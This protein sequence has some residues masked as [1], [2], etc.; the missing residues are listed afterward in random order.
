VASGTQVLSRRS[1]NRALL[2]RQ[3]LLHRVRLSAAAT[4]E[5]LVGM[6]AQVPDLPYVGLWS[7]LEAFDRQELSRLVETRRAVRASMHRCTIHLVTARD[8]LRLRPLFQPVLER[9][10]ERG[11]PFG[12]Q[13]AGVDR[14][15]LLA[16]GRELLGESPLT[17]SELGKLLGQRW[18]GMPPE[19]LAYALRYMEPLVF[20][21]PRG[22]WGGRGQ[23]RTTTVEAWLGRPVG[24]PSSLD[25]LVLRYL[26]AFGPA[27]VADMQAWSGMT[28]TREVFERLRLGLR[29]FRDVRGR[30]LFD[31]PRAP[32]PDPDT[33]ASPRFLPDYDNIL[34]AHADRSRILGPGKHIGMF[35]SNAVIKGSLLLDGFVRAIWMPIKGE[36]SSKVLIT[37]FDEPIQK[38]DRDQ[39]VAEGLRLL[40]FLAPGAKHSIQFGPARS[41]ATRRQEPAVPERRQPRDLSARSPAPPRRPSGSTASRR[42]A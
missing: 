31:L 14:Q 3:L 6:Q 36:R 27:T 28:R 33:P 41:S 32:R 40:A 12:R 2:A 19:P 17:V 34:L 21:P 25:D 22:T 24:P 16:A 39:V 38:K 30:E 8:Y 18:P 10:F 23:V 1:L 29:T 5:R 4:I 42:R 35:D 13:I 37:P 9:G 7:R 15:A 26:G 11:S 20:V